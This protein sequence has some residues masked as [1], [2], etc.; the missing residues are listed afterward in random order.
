MAMSGCGPK[1]CERQLRQGQ[2]ERHY[3]P[4]F[5]L[6][7]TIASFMS[8]ERADECRLVVHARAYAFAEGPL[9]TSQYCQEPQRRLL[10]IL[11]QQRPFVPECKI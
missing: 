7:P 4:G 11:I 1:D 2:D 8:D 9:H 5:R 3:Q 6:P 10:N